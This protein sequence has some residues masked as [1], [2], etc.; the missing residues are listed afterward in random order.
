MILNSPSPE[1][2]AA[3]A[4]GSLAPA[5]AEELARDLYGTRA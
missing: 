3:E 2:I 5:A 1:E 4:P